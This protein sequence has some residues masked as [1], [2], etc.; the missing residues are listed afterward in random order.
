M[1]RLLCT[2]ASLLAAATLF[3]GTPVSGKLDTVLKEHHSPDA[4]FLVGEWHYNTSG[5][6]FVKEEGETPPQETAARNLKLMTVT[7]DN[8]VL[9]FLDAN[10]CVFRVGDKK[11]KVACRINPE[12]R[13]LKATVALWSIKGWLVENGDCIDLIYTRSNL[14]LMMNYLCPLSTHKYIRELNS[15]LKC[16]D[17]LTLSIQFSRNQ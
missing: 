13:E 6:V 4:S 15:A 2:V 11:F 5:Y 8:C 1:R 14:E 17:G 9:T 16:T 3:A 12:T 7:P 10:T